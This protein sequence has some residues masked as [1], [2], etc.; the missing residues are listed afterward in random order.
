MS[1]EW[2][3]M[4]YTADITDVCFYYD[5]FQ[6]YGRKVCCL[7][8]I[9]ILGQFSDKWK[10]SIMKSGFSNSDIVFELL[11]ALGIFKHK[12]KKYVSNRYSSPPLSTGDTFQD[13][14]VDA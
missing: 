1:G 4:I 10:Q 5:T 12:I 11:T 13:P 2:E 6:A 9:D 14:S 7:N 3:G 8:K